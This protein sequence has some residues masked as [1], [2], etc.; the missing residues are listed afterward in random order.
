MAAPQADI[1][2]FGVPAEPR[3]AVLDAA[4]RRTGSSCLFVRD[5]R[6]RVRA[7][8]DHDATATA[9]RAA[10]RDP[11]GGASRARTG[12]SRWSSPPARTTARSPSSCWRRCSSNTG[13]AHRIGLTGVPGVGKST[14]L[15]AFGS[16]LT[17][18]RR[19]CRGA[20]GRPDLHAHRGLDPRGQD[21]YAAARGRRAGVRAGRHRPP[22]PSGGWPAA[23]ARRC[24]LCEAA[25]FDVVIVETV[26]VGQ[27]EVDR[28]ADGRRVRRA[29]AAGGRRRAAGHQEGACWRSRRS[30]RSTRP[31]ATRVRRRRDRAASSYRDA[32]ADPRPPTTARGRPGVLTLS[33]LAEQGIGEL[34]AVLSEHPRPPSRP[35]ASWTNAEPSSGAHWLWEQLESTLL[36]PSAHRR[37]P[38]TA[39]RGGRGRRRRGRPSG[40]GPA[41]GPP[42]RTPFLHGVLDPGRQSAEA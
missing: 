13:D 31:T 4:V 26:G 14:L 20:C 8:H 23:H 10:R 21:P 38:G 17:P 11:R 22:G 27:S 32:P 41:R 3:G 30:S 18:S 1:S 39:G 40:R 35:T 29:D 16:M 9:R 25:G 7:R 33:G 37:G 42:P 34:W 36:T 12:P 28:R 6:H 2:I 24:C 19:A 15:D 5:A